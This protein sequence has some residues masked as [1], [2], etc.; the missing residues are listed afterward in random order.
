MATIQ[1]FII[2]IISRDKQQINPYIVNYIQTHLP[3][4]KTYQNK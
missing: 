1:K 4:E 3:D 2:S